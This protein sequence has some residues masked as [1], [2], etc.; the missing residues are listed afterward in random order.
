MSLEEKKLS[1]PLPIGI[2]EFKK[3]IDNNCYYSDKTLLIKKLLDTKAEAILFARPRR[4][5]KTLNM[6]MLRTFFEKPLDGKDTSHY[7]KDLAIWKAG[8]KYTKEQGKRPVIYITFK[9]FSA[10]NF[11]DAI[12]SIA[13]EMQKECLRHAYLQKSEVLDSDEISQFREYKGLKASPAALAKSLKFLSGILAKH[14]GINAVILLDEYDKPVQDGFAYGYYDEIIRFMRGFLSGAFKDNP[15]LYRGVLTGITRVSKESIFSGLNNLLVDTIFDEE[16]SDSFG[17]TKSEVSDMLDFYDVPEKKEEAA[18][19]Y[20]GYMFG[21]TRIYNPWSMIQYVHS[22]CLARP[23]WLNTSANGLVGQALGIIDQNDRAILES[24]LSG[25]KAER[26]INTNIVYPD[27]TRKS[28][29]AYS[30]LA[31]TGYLKSTHT[32]WEEGKMIC[33][34]AIP[35]RELKTIYYDEILDRFV[36]DETSGLKAGE[37]RRAIS[38][39]NA[40]KIEQLVQDYLMSSLS[41]HDLTEE[42]DY[43][44]VFLGLVYIATDNYTIKSN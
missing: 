10:D 5:G 21:K 8:D 2:S 22:G 34:L 43:H 4:F 26:T 36:Q 28:S 39:G 16:F 9:D 35:N 29:A 20:D 12:Y 23:Y 14:Y 42:K 44:N 38:K 6:T 18:D 17:M 33:G 1:R 7:F 11:S 3:V 15:Y 13:S 32:E 30:L 40:E 31:Q 37:L 41:F 27:I 24:L 25:G 19:W